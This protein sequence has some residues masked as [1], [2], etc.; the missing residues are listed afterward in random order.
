M[1]EINAPCLAQTIDD[2]H[3]RGQG[4]GQGGTRQ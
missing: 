1:Q 3:E 4:K 2:E